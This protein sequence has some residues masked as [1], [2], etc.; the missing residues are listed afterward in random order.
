MNQLIW[1]IGGKIL[2]GE[3]E[4]FGENPVPVPLCRTQIS[5][6]LVW[7]WN[8]AFAVGGR[9]PSV[10][11]MAQSRSKETTPHP[12]EKISKKAYSLIWFDW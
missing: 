2:T 5:Y 7:D 4:V 10:C 8:R 12:C 6:W 1:T 3:T 11:V 9:L